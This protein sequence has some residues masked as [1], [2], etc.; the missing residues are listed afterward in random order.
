MTQQKTQPVQG[1]R[2]FRLVGRMVYNAM[3]DRRGQKC[4]A[5]CWGSSL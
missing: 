1:H 5:A 2:C 3:I 4:L